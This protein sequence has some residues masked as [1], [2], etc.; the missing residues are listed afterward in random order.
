[1]SAPTTMQWIRQAGHR[2]GTGSGRLAALLASG[3]LRR[4]RTV[5]RRCTGWLGESTGLAWLLRAG[6]LLLAAMAVRKVGTAVATGVYERAASGAAPGLLWGT[7]A[8]W[9][10]AAYRVGR[11]GWTP[12]EQPEPADAGTREEPATEADEPT[13]AAA[14]AER[15]VMLGELVR[16]VQSIGT[17]HAQLV[18]LAAHLGV[19]TDAV[20]ATAARAG[21]EVKDVRMQGRS[22]TH[23]LRADEAPPLPSPAP[24]RA[25]VGAGQPADDNDDDR[26]GGGRGEGL[27]VEAIGQAGVVVH[28][29]AEVVRHHLLRKS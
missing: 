8:V 11:E 3:T 14:P 24:S 2:I 27:R 13:P 1:M 22:S 7:A 10:I 6:L 23:G 20:R 19:T 9:V 5:W 28:H 29:P 26:G 15:P 25:V 18:P 21:W 12:K 16:A 4:G 17:P